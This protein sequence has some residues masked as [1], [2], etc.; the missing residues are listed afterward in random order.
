MLKRTM[1]KIA[2]YKPSG[3]I[4][5]ALTAAETSDTVS[6]GGNNTYFTAF[7]P[8]YADDNGD[9]S[10][11]SEA[12]L[13]F[14]GFGELYH[15]FYDELYMRGVNAKFIDK[16]QKNMAVLSRRRSRLILLVCFAQS[17][18]MCQKE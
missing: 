13:F 14:E 4:F 7:I 10:D 8:K 5:C 16:T 9:Y 11:I 1:R 12:P 15:D 3:K 18:A 6:I 17:P 2:A